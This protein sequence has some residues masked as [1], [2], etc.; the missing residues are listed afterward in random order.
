MKDATDVLLAFGGL[1]IVAAIT[2]FFHQTI[3]LRREKRGEISTR[4]SFEKCSLRTLVV[5]ALLIVIGAIMLVLGPL[6]GE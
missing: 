1:L 5:D 2:H 4:F 6:I 3:S